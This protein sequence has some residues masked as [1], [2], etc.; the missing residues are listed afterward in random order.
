[1]LIMFDHFSN[2]KMKKKEKETE[3]ISFAY[4]CFD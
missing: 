1:M 3:T 4:E 2:N